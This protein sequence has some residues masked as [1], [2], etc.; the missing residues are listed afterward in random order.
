MSNLL[1]EARLVAAMAADLDALPDD[2]G[3]RVMNSLLALYVQDETEVDDEYDDDGG[4]G[5]VCM[6]CGDPELDCIDGRC[7]YC[8]GSK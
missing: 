4:E 8:R 7:G 1:N 5:G 2:G 6:I 3:V